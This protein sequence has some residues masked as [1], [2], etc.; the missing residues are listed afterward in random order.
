MGWWEAR[1]PLYKLIVGGVGLAS[2]AVVAFARLLDARLPLR[3]R[4]VDVLV[5]GVLA[6]VCFCLGPAVELW[7]RRTL[8]SDRPVVGPVLFRYGLVFSV[9]LT[10]LPMPLTLLVML[11]RLLRIRVLGIPLS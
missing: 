2:V 6:N 11:V 4:A 10:L 1:R 3:V 9:G 7:L 5:Y 8:R